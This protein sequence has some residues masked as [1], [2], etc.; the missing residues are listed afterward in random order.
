MKKKIFISG[1]SGYIGSY[2]VRYLQEKYA[3]LAPTHTELDLLDAH[4]V[5]KFLYK[6]KPHTVIH[7]AVVGGSRRE[8]QVDSSLDNTLRMFYNLERCS[9][10]F[11]KF[12]HLGSGAE[13]DKSR[14]IK[15]VKES[16]Y[17][18]FIPH[19]S[20]GFSKY[21]ISKYIEQSSDKFVNLRLF[22]IF[23]YGEDYRLRFISN[24]LVRKILGLPFIISRNAVF[25]Y[26][27]IDDL[28]KII[29][30]FIDHSP[31]FRT[32]NIGS[33]QPK[34]LLAIA[35]KV[36]T[37]IGP[38]TKIQVLMK[39]LNQEYTCDNT[40]LIKELGSF[41]FSSFDSNLRELYN[42]YVLNRKSLKL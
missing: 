26:I 25:D 37:M 6:Y 23:G 10:Y 31:R 13:Y 34:S 40:R 38:S 30:Y 41:H 18:N 17:G 1:G 14:S 7:A 8:E 20:Y 28:L 35:N 42:L 3:V 2:L 21:V 4:K 15:Q 5:E 24:M 29:S 22:G 19:D 32:Y 12:I 27:Y 16:E 9:S 36:N 39:G 11:T 33:G